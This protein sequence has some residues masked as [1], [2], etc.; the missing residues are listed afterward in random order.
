M[1]SKRGLKT[2]VRLTLLRAGRRASAKQLANLRNVLSYLE[3]G[4]WL[5]SE[6]ADTR[7]DVVEDEF[8]LFEV[9]RRRVVGQ[10]PLYLEF[11]VF[12]GR[13]LR[14]WSSHLTQ[15][16]ARLVG[17][18][19]FEGLPENWRP[20]ID[21]GH[22]QTGQPPEIDDS[23]VSFEVGW[24]DDTLP[25]FKVPDHDQMIVNVDSDLYSSAATVLHWAE[26]YLRP[27]TLIYFDE[28]PDRDHE[29]KAFNE[30]RARSA[31]TFAPVAIAHGGVH[32]LFEAR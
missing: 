26:P 15:P 2:A 7:L 11:G 4:Q 3:L 9:A 25:Q 16:G 5:A 22:F 1:A 29:M 21:A 8:A 27:G 17:F 31:L 18:D 30:L 19:S 24:F 28:F 13:S 12:E 32:W 20:G 10:A 23:R 14:W 6:H